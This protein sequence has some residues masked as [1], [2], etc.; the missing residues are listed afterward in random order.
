MTNMTTQTSTLPLNDELSA[1]VETAEI[2]A[3]FVIDDSNEQGEFFTLKAKILT[4]HPHMPSDA[5]HTLIVK[6]GVSQSDP[7]KVGDTEYGFAE[8]YPSISSA[9]ARAAAFLHM[10]EVGTVGK[11]REAPEGFAN[12][13]QSFHSTSAA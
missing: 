5:G 2:D 3:A 1:W 10:L 7:M 11:F 4:G 12:L 13:A 9:L 6:A 8:W